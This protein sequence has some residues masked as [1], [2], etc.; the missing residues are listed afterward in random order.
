[1]KQR[2]NVVRALSRKYEK[3]KFKQSCWEA[4]TIVTG[5]VEYRTAGKNQE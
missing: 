3:G 2:E 5:N 1:M 4:E